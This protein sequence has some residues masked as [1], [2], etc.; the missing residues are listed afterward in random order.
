MYKLT[1]SFGKKIALIFL[2]IWVQLGDVSGQ[3]IPSSVKYF[4]YDQGLPDKVVYDIHQDN[5]GM[6]WVSTSIGLS[7][8]DGYK[9][10]NFS[11]LGN[12]NISKKINIRGAGFISEDQFQNLIISPW[13]NKDRV[14]IFNIYSFESSE[15]SLIE[16]EAIQGNVQDIYTNPLDHCYILSKNETHFFLYKINKSRQV[17]LLYS[18]PSDSNSYSDK[19]K[20][21]VSS[22]NDFWIFDY[23]FQK[24][25][26]FIDGKN[27]QDFLINKNSSTNTQLAI[28]YQDKNGT[29]W[30]SS[31]KDQQTYKILPNKKHV[32]RV[33]FIDDQ[34]M[35][36]RVY[37][38]QKGNLI[39]ANQD[40]LYIYD[41]L[42]YS[43]L[44]IQQAENKNTVILNNILETESKIT[45]LE[46]SDFFEYIFVTSH[47]GFYQLLFPSINK[48]IKHFLSKEIKAGEFGAIMRGMTADNEGT[49]YVNTEG[50][51]WYTLK[52]D[53]VIYLLIVVV[54]SILFLMEPI[55]GVL[56]VRI[57]GKV[58]CI[59]MK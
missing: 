21:H 12:S 10:K 56:P 53:K 26:H 42:L 23:Q 44:P 40:E 58:W 8:F 7:M 28:F 16:N 1:S 50:G 37:E 34:P 41:L 24:I 6:M 18:I 49:I 55:F 2:L 59:D 27:H 11:N 35:Y 29:F 43:N 3:L 39:F 36:T 46:G 45:N 15:I 4:S 25:T 13:E 30:F 9:F 17:E 22:S 19:N 20:L 54:T 33:L 57:E 52:M 32:E 48:N 38:D 14:E 31:S 5:H 47:N 51:K